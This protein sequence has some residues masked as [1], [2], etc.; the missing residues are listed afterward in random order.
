MLDR[1]GEPLLP[2][3]TLPREVAVGNGTVGVEEP[4]QAAL[5]EALPDADPLPDPHPGVADEF[6]VSDSRGV[7]DLDPIKECVPPPVP[8][9]P[10]VRVPLK[11]VA[12][13]HPEVEGAT[14]PLAL[15]KDSEGSPVVLLRGVT[16][17]VVTPERLGLTE[18]EG[19]PLPLLPPVPVPTPPPVP[20]GAQG[21]T[22]VEGDTA[23][24]DLV[25]APG[26]PLMDRDTL[27]EAEAEG[28][29]LSLPV[30]LTVPVPPPP[31]PEL[32]EGLGE[33]E[34]EKEGEEDGDGEGMEVGVGPPPVPLPCPLLEGLASP[35]E[36]REGAAGDRVGIKGVPVPPPNPPALAV[37]PTK[38]GEELAEMDALGVLENEGLGDT[39][40][41]VRLAT[42][43]PLESVVGDR[44]GVRVTPAVSVA[45]PP[46]TFME[47]EALG[48]GLEEGLFA[49]PQDALA[50]LGVG[51]GGRDGGAER[52]R[53][54]LALP[55]EEGD[56][57]GD[58]LAAPKG[59]PVPSPD[60]V[61][62]AEASMGEEVASPEVVLVPPPPLL[63]VTVG[64]PE[65]S[66]VAVGATADGVGESDAEGVDVAA[67]KLGDADTVAA[68]VTVRVGCDEKVALAAVPVG[69]SPLGLPVVVE[70]RDEMEDTLGEGV[71]W[72]LAEGVEVAPWE[73]AAEPEGMEREGRGERDTE[74]E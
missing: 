62:E 21:V 44:E 54:V 5:P 42:W 37:A 66:P 46:K 68:R 19:L 26:D 38:V 18:G 73:A 13:A 36:V 27:G 53:L 49:A 33:R 41:G 32:T 35:V 67:T 1:V 45:P 60:P 9:L 10:A 47:E 63:G 74:G 50:P 59:L 48:E 6:G 12:D 25:G 2:A 39:S 61:A 71:S 24:P 15:P 11:G 51:V 56:P 4:L 40:W 31:K 29:L 70:E 69:A 3:E 52:L 16:V 65:L 17:K 64:T 30:L 14:L 43:V 23:P 20:V 58:P 72:E 28:G 34:A 57:E 55:L 7:E 22:V 8:L